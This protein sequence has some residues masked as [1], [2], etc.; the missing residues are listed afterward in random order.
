MTPR[1]QYLAM[2]EKMASTHW[3]TSE[4]IAW[5]NDDRRKEAILSF[6]DGP[7]RQVAYAVEAALKRAREQQQGTKEDR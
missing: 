4:L 7:A 6:T 3:D 5:I 1:Q 2:I